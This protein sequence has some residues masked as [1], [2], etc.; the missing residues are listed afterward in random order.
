MAIAI[1][2]GKQ[3]GIMWGMFYSV[4][5]I[6]VHNKILSSSVHRSKPDLMIVSGQINTIS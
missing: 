3:Y 4:T 2:I 6:T 1:N 5:Q